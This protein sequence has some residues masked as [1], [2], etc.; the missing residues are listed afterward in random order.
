MTIPP[1]SASCQLGISGVIICKN[2]RS[3]WFYLQFSK[4]VGCQM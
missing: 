3:R 1:I 2:E 4:S